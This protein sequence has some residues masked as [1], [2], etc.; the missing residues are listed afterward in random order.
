MSDHDSSI[1]ILKLKQKIKDLHNKFKLLK[2]EKKVN[3]LY[4]SIKS[5]NIDFKKVLAVFMIVVMIGLSYTAY[6]I[7]EINTRAFAV[8]L[9]GEQIGVVRTEEEALKIMEDIKNDL[10]A[11]YSADCV[12][13]KELSFEPTHVKDDELTKN[14]TLKNTIK[15][16][17]D[18][19]VAGY[20]ISIDGKSIGTVKSEKDAKYIIDSIKEPYTSNVEGEL[21]EVKI[22]EHFEITKNEVPLNTLTTPADLTELIKVGTEEIKT[23]VV[24]VGESFWT[25]AMMYDTTVDELIEANPDKNP[26]KL[27]IGDEVKLV[28][29]TSMLTVATVEKVE[30]TKDTEY[31]TV[32]EESSSMYK[33]QQKVKVEGQKGESFVVSN[34]V[35]HNGILVEEEIINEEVIKK[36]VDELVVKGTKEIPKTMAT[37]IFMMPTRGRFTSGYGSRWGR[38]HRGID[39]AASTG[40]PIYAADGG[41]VTHSGWQGTYGYMIEIDH[42]NGYKTRYAHASKLLVGKGK[43]VYKG[44]HIAN[45]GNTGRSTGPHLH[46]EVLKNGVHVNPSKYV[47]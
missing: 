13:D 35:K 7:N 11:T 9:D 47:K 33:N 22:L 10:S 30:Y 16:N 43:K 15:S 24:E 41:T 42:G 20:T 44:Q 40:S 32:V 23:H 29:P 31:E 4:T 3:D 18:F 27:Q 21:K 38:M 34:Q 36:P 12:L 17:I 19:L 1:L 45:V 37:G 6:K 8:S 28:V 5:T 46:L 14:E 39:I 26:S 25:I 2:L